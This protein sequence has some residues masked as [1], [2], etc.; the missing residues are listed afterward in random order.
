LKAAVDLPGQRGRLEARYQKSQDSDNFFKTVFPTEF[1]GSARAEL[2]AFDLGWSGLVAHNG[3]W[4]LRGELGYRYLRADQ[5]VSEITTLDPS[6]VTT[7]GH[8]STFD[9]ESQI[10][11]HGLR[12]GWELSVAIGG[13]LHVETLAGFTLLRGS[14][15]GRASSSFDF[16]PGV[17]FINEEDIDRDSIGLNTWDLAVR[18]RAEFWNR[19]SASLGYRFD[20]WESISRIP[21]TANLSFDGVTA[22]LGY[23]FGL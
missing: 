11:G 12:G 18:L 20:R 13:P 4:S 8:V 14:E 2:T 17:V 10:R 3:P 9:S 16:E 6:V 15:K 5:D 7:D 21:T 23:R 19:L 1:S 22:G